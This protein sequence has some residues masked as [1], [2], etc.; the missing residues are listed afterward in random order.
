[1]NIK[2]LVWDMDGVLVHVGNSYRRAIVDSLSYYLSRFMGLD[3]DKNP[4]SVYDTQYF[5]LAG[6]FN[7]DWE[8]TYSAVLCYLTKVISEVDESR[9]DMSP[10]TGDFDEMIEALNV[11]GSLYG[12]RAPDLDLREITDKIKINGGGP[13]GTEKTLREMFGENLDIARRFLFN[14]LIKRVFQEI[15]LGEEFF[16]EKYGEEARFVKSNGLIREEESLVNLDILKVLRDNHYFGIASGRERFEIE[17]T[18][19]LHNF[20][21]FF[22]PDLIV[23]SEDVL[24]GKPHPDQLLECRKRVFE[25]HHLSDGD[26][27]Y[28]GDS[29]DDVTAAQRAG[30][31]SIGCLC[32]ALTS[33]QK[34]D[35]MQE[36][37]EMGCDLILE[38]PN[39]LPPYLLD[40]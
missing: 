17:I 4:M 8:L 14:D 16:K 27:V 12:D 34:E 33:E 30:F 25:K 13:T 21:E 40:V 2:V 31:F 9:I 36:L 38:N 37:H 15:Y 18:L 29:I 23:S 32:G 10:S 1:M 28:I 24:R 11:L 5:K 26:A 7:N 3:L 20:S 19:K 22:D 35:L 39:S 6:K